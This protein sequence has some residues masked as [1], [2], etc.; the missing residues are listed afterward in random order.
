MSELVNQPWKKD[1]NAADLSARVEKFE[2]HVD[3]LDRTHTKRT[4][5]LKKVLDKLTDTKSGIETTK[6][7]RDTTSAELTASLK[8]QTEKGDK[9]ANEEI[10]AAQQE[11][12]EKTVKDAD[13][14]EKV[15][16]LTNELAAKTTMT[17]EKKTLL[18][19]LD[20]AGSENVDQISELEDTIKE[21]KA[22]IEK[23]GP[24]I[25]EGKGKIE[26]FT[27]HLRR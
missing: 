20:I 5:D 14:Q 17:A 4:A 13:M 24:L 16:N 10:P 18:Q 2:K 8:A 23:I 3:L 21:M 27:A 9:L 7:H 26:E 6:D 12:E 11:L 19:N 22:Q 1:P 15:T 25:Q